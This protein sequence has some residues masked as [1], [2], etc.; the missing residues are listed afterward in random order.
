MERAGVGIVE[1]VTAPLP[2][3]RPLFPKYVTPEPVYPDSYKP[4][5]L[6]DSMFDTDT[7]TGF[8]GG[9]VAPWLPG[10]RFSVFDN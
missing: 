7:Y 5:L 4:G 8:S 6:S 10:S 9:D 2:P 1:M 3:Y